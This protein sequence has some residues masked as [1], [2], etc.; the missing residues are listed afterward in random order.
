MVDKDVLPS[1]LYNL[2]R[3]FGDNILKLFELN[4]IHDETMNKYPF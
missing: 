2:K 4:Y 3:V 1:S